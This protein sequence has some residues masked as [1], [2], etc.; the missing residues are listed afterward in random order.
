MEKV[1]LKV[2]GRTWT[3]LTGFSHNVFFH[4]ESEVK[5]NT[6]RTYYSKDL[7]KLKVNNKSGAGTDKLCVLQWPHFQSLNFLRDT[8]KPRKTISSLVSIIF[9]RK[10][11]LPR[12]A[13]C[14]TIKIFT[15]L[16]SHFF[17]I[18]RTVVTS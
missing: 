12:Y 9:L 15:K 6:L 2:L 5:I 18:K 8:I 17:C 13:T 11:V 14:N 16:L 4:L 10:L 3:A 7:V 1:K